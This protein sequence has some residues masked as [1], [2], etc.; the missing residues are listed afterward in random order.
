M[1]GCGVD[2]N[3]NLLAGFYEG[4]TIAIT[5][6]GGS[7]GQL[8]TRRLLQLN[9]RRLIAIDID[10]TA[11]RALSTQTT[12]D[13][14]VQ[15]VL[16]DITEAPKLAELFTGTEIVFHAAAQK[17]ICIAEEDPIGTLRI[18]AFG[19]ANVRNAAF[20]A[21]VDRL[22]FTS[23]DKAVAPTGTMGASKLIGERIL[24]GIPT[25][26]TYQ[27]QG[28]RTA[29][30][31]FGN[32]GGSSGS[33]IPRFHEAIKL[34][35]PIP[36]TDPN[37]TR[38][39][40][41]PRQASDL[42]LSSAILAQGGEIL[43]AKMPSLRIR[44]L[45][46][47]M[48]RMLAT[49]YGWDPVNYPIEVKGIR[50]GEKL[51][52]ELTSEAENHRLMSNGRFLCVLPEAPERQKHLRARYQNEGFKTIARI[53]S[54]ESEP[55]MTPQQIREFLLQQDVLPESVQQACTQTRVDTETHAARQTEVA[56]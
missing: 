8:L 28:T 33:V 41:T 38:F 32:I 35:V 29:S 6:A 45:A 26:T 2:V 53:Y 44:D 31:R 51:K 36:L 30:L 3:C 9:I 52:E 11:L 37:M 22:V 17:H 50:A 16:Q 34:G 7:V 23:S 39:V 27:N 48:V 20:K 21:G 15:T 56:L 42:V 12:N 10:P 13:P 47:E 54:S 55:P 24:A 19:L 40:M 18:N 14:R 49:H 46:V 43:I 5:G 4:R 1:V 25:E